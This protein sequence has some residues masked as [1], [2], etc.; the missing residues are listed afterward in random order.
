[1]G[2]VMSYGRLIGRNCH[3]TR[4]TDRAFQF[5]EENSMKRTN[6]TAFGSRRSAFIP[7][8]QTVADNIPGLPAVPV[9]PMPVMH[10]AVQPGTPSVN[11]SR[12]DSQTVVIGPQNLPV[13][14]ARPA[15]S[16][17]DK[18]EVDAFRKTL[19]RA[20]RAGDHDTVESLLRH[21]AADEI[22]M[23]IDQV[24]KNAL[25]YAIECQNL[26]SV[27]RLLRLASASE[28][29]MRRTANGDYPLM[30]AARR[31]MISVVQLL[32][33]L[34]SAREQLAQSNELGLCPPLVAAGLGDLEVLNLMVETDAKTLFAKMKRGFNPLHLAAGLGRLPVVD[35]LIS[36]PMAL[37][38]PR[39]RLRMVPTR[40]MWPP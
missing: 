4:G 16:V 18:S 21:E 23:A 12:A 20:I 34:S 2:E 35:Y 19:H 14:V 17:A 22:A 40:C 33:G 26:Q 39:Q 28:Q 5:Y 9:I 24:G 27:R 1:M 11:R 29:A 13:L 36:S 10:Q 6:D 37:H 30:H 32:L 7:F 31:G 3:S 15:S 38:W 8:R 25:C